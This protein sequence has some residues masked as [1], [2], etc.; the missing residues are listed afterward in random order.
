ML[1]IYITPGHYYR[2]VALAGGC[3]AGVVW[4]WQG[5]EGISA[6]AGCLGIRHDDSKWAIVFS[7]LE[8]SSPMS[9]RQAS[10]LSRKEPRPHLREAPARPLFPHSHAQSLE[11]CGA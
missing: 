10:F 7:V 2:A 8:R 11:D 1:R 6:T 5:A 4:T 9:L 3:G